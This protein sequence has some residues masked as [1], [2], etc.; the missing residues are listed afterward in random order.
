M[1]EII[2]QLAK[3]AIA[4]ALGMESQFD[5]EQALKNYPELEKDGAA[6]VTLTKE[7]QDQLRGCIGSLSAYQPLYKDIIANAQSAALAMIS[8]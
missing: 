8:L 1:G 4:V 2:I 6:F 3:A 5:L 7:P